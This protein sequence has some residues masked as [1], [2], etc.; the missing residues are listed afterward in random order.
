LC[1]STA[2]AGGCLHREGMRASSLANT[3]MYA[4]AHSML[5]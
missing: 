5:E 2:H 3:D 1:P 4:F